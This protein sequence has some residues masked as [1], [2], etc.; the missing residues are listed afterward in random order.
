M[1]GLVYRRPPALSLSLSSCLS[2]SHN[3]PLS[4]IFSL[5][6]LYFFLLATV[7][8]LA[9]SPSRSITQFLFSL[10]HIIPPLSF[11]SPVSPRLSHTRTHTHAFS[12]SVYSLLVS[13]LVCAYAA[14]PT[15]RR[16]R[17][18]CCQNPEYELCVLN[19]QV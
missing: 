8:S 7:S 11:S 6:S 2:I 3:H 12:P 19:L 9:P 10:G 16:H 5:S 17:N 15:N 1:A 13:L 4:L 14:V 18:S